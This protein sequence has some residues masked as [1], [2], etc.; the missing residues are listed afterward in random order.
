MGL[1][2]LVVALLRRLKNGQDRLNDVPFSAVRA[3][4]MAEMS[5][6]PRE[7]STGNENVAPE[8]DLTGRRP[9]F[10]D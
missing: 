4:R 7:P 9:D 6:Q 2:S 1:W 5:L 3:Y 8:A 10:S